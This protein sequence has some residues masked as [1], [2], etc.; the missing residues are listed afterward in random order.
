MGGIPRPRRFQA[1]FK[2]E[3]SVDF[4]ASVGLPYDDTPPID[5][6]LEM[7]GRGGAEEVGRKPKLGGDAK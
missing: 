5:R 2:W 3:M 6:V 1:Y 4:C 7:M